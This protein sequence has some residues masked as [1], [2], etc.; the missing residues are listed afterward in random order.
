MLGA[1][2]TV[3]ALA[4]NVQAQMM[5]GMS[6]GEMMKGWPMDAAKAANMVMKKYGAA[7]EATPS[8]I[9]WHNAGPWKRIVA[10]RTPIMHLFPAKHP[11]SVEMF[12]DYRVPLNKYDDLARFDGSVNVDRTRGEMS[13]RCDADTHNFLA[14]NLAH[15]IIMG[16]RSVAGARA[17]YGRVVKMEKEKMV[18]HPYEMHLMFKPMM[19]M[20]SDP[21]KMTIMVKK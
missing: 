13:A 8:T 1:V 5:S 17:F 19:N 21:D 15:D 3:G 12:I 7:D 4:S 16:K 18:L 6:A 9:T 20:S 11:D 10:S 2:V 14:L